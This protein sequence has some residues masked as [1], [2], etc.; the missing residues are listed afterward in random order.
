M[1]APRIPR[2]DTQTGFARTDSGR[3]VYGTGK[4]LIG[5][6]SGESA[7]QQ[8]SA[9]EEA[10]Q[11]A[12]LRLRRR[13][14]HVIGYGGAMDPKRRAPS[15]PSVIPLDQSLLAKVSRLLNALRLRLKGPL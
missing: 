8:P 12:L 5:I 2:H 13:D 7:K 11:S 10:I 15:R 14:N 9:D 3:L 6:R 4:V 1:S